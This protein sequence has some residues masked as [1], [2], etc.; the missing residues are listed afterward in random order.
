MN[1]RKNEAQA[2]SK[3]IVCPQEVRSIFAIAF[4]LINLFDGEDEERLRRKLPERIEELKNAVTVLQ[5]FVDAHFEA[6]K[7][8][9]LQE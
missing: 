5:P 2:H 4:N 8:G 1:E 9:W 3:C 7:E 6:L